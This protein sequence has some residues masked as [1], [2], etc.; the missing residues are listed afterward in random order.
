LFYQKLYSV[1]D[2]HI[3][4]RGGSLAT[5]LAWF[6]R[7]LIYLI[8]RKFKAW[9]RYKRS[10]RIHD[11]NIFK[12]LRA[13]VKEKERHAY[14]NYVTRMNANVKANPKYFWSFMNSIKKST[15]IPDVMN[16]DIERYRSLRSRYFSKS[17]MVNNKNQQ[18]NQH[19]TELMNKNVLYLNDISDDDVQKAIKKLKNSQTAGPDLI[20]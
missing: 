8:R 15:S 11:Y 16:Y 10:D 9:Q 7:E 19:L 14:N 12:Q 18:S 3:P 6:D 4:R 20:R 17:F 5:Y 13:E 1:F 2:K